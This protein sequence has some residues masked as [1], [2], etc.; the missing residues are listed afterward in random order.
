MNNTLNQGDEVI[1]VTSEPSYKHT[2]WTQE[3]L[4]QDGKLLISHDFLSPPA[5]ISVGEYVEFSFCIY[6]GRVLK[7]THYFREIIE[8]DL[9]RHVISIHLDTDH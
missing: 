6:K 3:F 4:D 5:Q 8:S 7:I 2:Q 9:L 1:K